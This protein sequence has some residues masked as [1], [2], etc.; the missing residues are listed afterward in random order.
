MQDA[1]I[2]VVRLAEFAKRRGERGVMPHLAAFFKAP[3]GVDEFR[4]HEQHR[5]LLD[6]AHRARGERPH[7]AP[8]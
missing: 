4:L 6:Y 1:G 8:N 2:N 3:L 5:M 7:S